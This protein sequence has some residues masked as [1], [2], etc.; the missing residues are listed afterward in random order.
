[1]RRGK[2]VRSS[3]G[4]ANHLIW[5]PTGGH[6]GDA[7][8]ITS[9]FAEILRHQP[10]MKIQYLVRRNAPFI[11]N[12]AAA[13]PAITIIP[14]PNAPLGALKALLPIFKHRAI[15]VAPPSWG[16]HPKV[17]KMLMLV[18]RLRGDEVVGYEDG[19]SF[20]PWHIR[21]SR[22][23]Q[24]ERYIDSLRRAA[25]AVGLETESLG[26]PPQLKLNA[27]MPEDFPFGGKRY[28][29]IHPFPHMATFKTIPLHRWKDLVQWLRKEYPEF[30]LVITGAEVDRSKAEEINSV[31]D[32]SIYL[33][34]NR[35]LMDV[36]GLIENATLYI[37]VD[38]GPTHIAGVLSAPSVV[39]AHQNEPTWLPSYNPNA[40]L[41]W[42]KER[43]V[44][45]VP[46]EVCFAEEDGLQYR[47]C[48]YYIPDKQIH[49]AIRAK[50][51][52]PK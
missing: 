20:Q 3:K 45:G 29:V 9:L 18:L 49:D 42:N 41:L 46:G 50:I 43:C 38:T 37:G 24:K 21:V 48:V 13:Y 26:S 44:C 5:V 47:R 15:V 19:T 35:P 17:I 40:V 23:K 51:D 4:R 34:I 32:N 10:E 28:L 30:G 8:M 2:T 31:I 11:A 27:T 25:N 16:V 22:E 7:V 33:A 39:L 6:I 14:I 12:L 36:A 52:S 1:M